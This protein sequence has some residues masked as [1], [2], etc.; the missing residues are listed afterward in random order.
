MPPNLSNL[1]A[2]ESAFFLRE[3]EHVK[4][5]TYDI[6]YD[7]FKARDLIPVSREAGPGAESIVYQ[8]FS[9]VGI[10]KIIADYADDLPRADVAGA[11][12]SSP[13]KSIGDSYGYSVQEIRAAQRAGRPLNQRKASAAR[14]AISV[15]EESIAS[16]GD[17]QTGLGGLLNNANVT[18]VVAATKTAGGTTWAVATA[19]E[20]L[21]DLQTLFNTIYAATN[22][23]EAPDTIVVPAPQYAILA[24]T[25]INTISD[26]TVLEFFLEKYRALGVRSVE[27]WSECELAG[28]GSTDLALAYVRNPDYCTLE[29]PQDFEQFPEQ[30]RNLEY[31]VPCH[32]RIGGVLIYYPVAFASLYG[33]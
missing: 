8:W 3:L 23:H 31:V 11:E 33:I 32:E 27:S 30:Q 7:K 9:M 21:A 20:L 5:K 19:T 14:R 4:A 22:G 28:T 6:K 2:A 12:T 26:K 10:A 25:P 29:I 18:T 13:V 15:V 24:T 16:L 1:D 17:S